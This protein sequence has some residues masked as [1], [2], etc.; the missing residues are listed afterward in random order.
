M[1]TIKNNR[2]QVLYTLDTNT[3][4]KDNFSQYYDYE[5]FFED[6]ENLDTLNKHDIIHERLIKIFKKDDMNALNKIMSKYNHKNS[7]RGILRTILMTLKPIKT[8]VVIHKMYNNLSDILREGNTN[9]V[10]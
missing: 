1:V 3:N 2:G 9:G 10:I 6:I 8:N 4:E 7:D 5:D